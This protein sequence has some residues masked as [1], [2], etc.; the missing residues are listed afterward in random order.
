MNF[1]FSFLLLSKEFCLYAIEK[2][3]NRLQEP[4]RIVRDLSKQDKIILQQNI[5]LSN[6]VQDLSQQKV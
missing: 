6:E 2:E 5:I 1:S 4:E 3:E